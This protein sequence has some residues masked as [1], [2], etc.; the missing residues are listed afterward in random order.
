[1]STATIYA[2]NDGFLNNVSGWYGAETYNLSRNTSS[3]SGDLCQAFIKFTTVSAGIGAL[4]TINTVTFNWNIYSWSDINLVAAWAFYTDVN[5][6]WD[7]AGTWNDSTPPNVPSGVAFGTSSDGAVYLGSTGWNT[8]TLT[9]SIPKSGIFGVC[10]DPQLGDIGPS[11][12]YFYAVENGSNYP[13]ITIDY[14]PAPKG[15]TLT[16]MGVG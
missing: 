12:M 2:T 8:K 14:T 5:N 13:Y 6:T 4:D 10:I 16:M 1:M 11:L 15:G 7:S 9:T 3:S